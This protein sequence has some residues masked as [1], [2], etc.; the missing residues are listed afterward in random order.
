MKFFESNGFV[1][2]LTLLGAIIGYGYFLWVRD[3]SMPAQVYGNE[4]IS[5]GF[6]TG[7]GF[8][9]GLKFRD[10]FRKKKEKGEDGK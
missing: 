9:F 3:F 10:N 4:W 5:T 8:L 7:M 2:I 1:F 6:G